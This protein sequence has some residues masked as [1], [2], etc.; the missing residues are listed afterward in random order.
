MY[1]R[2]LKSSGREIHLPALIS[3]RVSKQKL[4]FKLYKRIPKMKNF[5]ITIVLM[6]TVVM[7]VV[8]AQTVTKSW[9]FGFGLDYPR[10]AS[11]NITSLNSN[12]G[13]YLSIQR[14]FSENV[15]LR[16]KGGY[17]HIEGEWSDP[18][19]VLN[20]EETNLITGNIDLLYYLVPC[21]PVSPYIFA[22]VGGNYRSITNGQTAFADDNK[23]GS[24]LNIGTGAEI[25]F[26]STWSLV[27]EFGYHVTNNSKLDGT[28]APTEING[29]DSYIVLSAGVNMLFGKGEVS[30]KC[31]PCQ[32]ITKPVKDMT[33]YDK[34]EDMI[35]KH[36]PKE[37]TKEV[38]V[39][40]YIKAISD[41]RIVLVGVNFAFDKSELLPESYSVLDKAV[42]LLNENPTVNVEIEGY[43]DYV[44]TAQY[45]QEL[46]VERAET[47]KKYLVSK[48][49]NANR[50]STIGYGKGNP[51]A[52][53]DTEEG[54]AM[55]RRIVFRIIK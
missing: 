47:V 23:F 1:C 33:D 32:G 29:R 18:L 35:K 28:I 7:G 50:L 31:E 10:F 54:R 8:Q 17:N 38:I 27:T 22:G 55:N 6:F 43:T 9:A 13:G 11:A 36:I 16:L 44:G 15:G 21:A 20:T 45:N 46:S 12:Y 51:V 14:N 40:R 2:K 34:I 49:I 42:N 30:K 39:D 5:I 53:N 48:G 41:D 37:V 3:K 25:K 26:N 52:K 4:I 19:F 24:Q